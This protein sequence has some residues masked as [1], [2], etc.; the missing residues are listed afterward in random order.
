GTGTLTL[1]NHAGLLRADN[2][3]RTLANPI[4]VAPASPFTSNFGS[5]GVNDLTLSGNVNGVLATVPAAAST[6]TVVLNSISRGTTTF[7]GTIANGAAF[8]LGVTKNGPGVVAVNGN[9]SYTGDSIVNA[10][11][12]RLG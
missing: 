8:N 11:T 5:T 2:G 6:M 10:G 3:A 7:G 4:N 12:V 9:N 1:S